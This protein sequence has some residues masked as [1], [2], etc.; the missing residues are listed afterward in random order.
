MTLVSLLFYG[1]QAQLY[2]Q[3]LLWAAGLRSPPLDLLHDEDL[4]LVELLVERELAS[5]SEG[6]G[7]TLVGALERFLACVNVGVLL[8]VLAERELLV[9]YHAD[10]LLGRGVR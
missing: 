3:A 4:V 1:L 9:A 2:F 7:A 8:Q 5:L 6:L 10:I